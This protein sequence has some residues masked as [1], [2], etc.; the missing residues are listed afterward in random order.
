M[1]TFTAINSDPGTGFSIADEF[2]TVGNDGQA[3]TSDAVIIY[4]SSNGNLFYN[5]NGS[6]AGFDNGGQFATLTNTLSLIAED[7]FLRS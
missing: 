7:F 6:E 5:P 2:A 4:N 1:G 3:V